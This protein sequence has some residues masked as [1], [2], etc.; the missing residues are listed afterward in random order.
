MSNDSRLRPL[1]RRIL[2]LVDDGVDEDEIARRFRRSPG[3]IGRV[4]ALTR[5]PRLD[6]VDRSAEVLRPLERRV[7]RWR[8]DGA[9]Y[10]EIGHRFGRSAGFVAQVEGLAR[11]KLSRV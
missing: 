2:Q 11:Y 3:M 10:S 8:D 6:S 1:E 7:L 4:I 5:L 9:D